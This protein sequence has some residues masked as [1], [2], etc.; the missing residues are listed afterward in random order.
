M[1]FSS[2]CAE[3]RNEQRRC[4][5]DRPTRGLGAKIL[6]KANKDSKVKRGVDD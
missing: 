4:N 6:Q 2:S 3:M 5:M 1:N